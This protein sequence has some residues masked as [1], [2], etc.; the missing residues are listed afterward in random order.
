MTEGIAAECHRSVPVTRLEELFA[1]RAGFERPCERGVEVVDVEVQMHRRP[2]TFVVTAFPRTR[3]RLRA[4]GLLEQT[5]LRVSR[6]EHDE[7]GEGLRD[8][9]EAEDARLEADA[10][11]EVRHVY[12][13]RYRDHGGFLMPGSRQR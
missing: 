9:P 5:D 8:L 12:A 2:M 6:I 1:R 4:G 3:G 10:V 7:A 11:R 13:E